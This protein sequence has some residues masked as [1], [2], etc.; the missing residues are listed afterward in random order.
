VEKG[1]FCFNLK[2]ARY[3][4]LNQQVSKE[5]YLRVKMILLEYINRELEEKAGLDFDI[6]SIGV[7]AKKPKN[8]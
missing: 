3:A 5:E 6:F 8:Q 1:I 7:A 2:G 4:V